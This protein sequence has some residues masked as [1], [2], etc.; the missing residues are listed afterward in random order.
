MELREQ[1][2]HCVQKLKNPESPDAGPAFQQLGRLL[3]D[4]T[5]E[6]VCHCAPVLAEIIPELA[7]M[8][9]FDQRSPH[10]AYDLLTHTARVV[11]QVEREETV[12][13]A[14]LLHD[15]GKVPTFTRDETGRGHFYGHAE[16]GTAMAEKILLRLGAPAAL[17]ERA[18]LL[19]AHHMT[20]LP[21]DKTLLREWRDV[22]GPEALAQLLD[23]QRADMSS[24][25]TE[26]PEVDYLE[27]FRILGEIPEEIL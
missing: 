25:G 15:V 20:R 22:L 3:C 2:F 4:M 27:I 6:D 11:A 9:G 21:A 19:I 5:A 23:L 1:I 8:A 16:A 14:A 10:H 24:K 13:W 18:V 17:R 26:P 12:R 7:P